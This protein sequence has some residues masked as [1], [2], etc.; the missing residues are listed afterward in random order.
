MKEGE[1]S[2][3]SH[4]SLNTWGMHLRALDEVKVCEQI[5]LA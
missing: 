2:E 4:G 3:W 1:G 5:M